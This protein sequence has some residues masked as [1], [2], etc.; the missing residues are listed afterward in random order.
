MTN[1]ADLLHGLDVLFYNARRL[2]VSYSSF[3]PEVVWRHPASLW[4]SVPRDEGHRVALGEEAADGGG[5]G[6]APAGAERG[7]HR[8][9]GPREHRTTGGVTVG[10]QVL[11]LVIIQ[12]LSL[13][14]L[15][16]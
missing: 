7:K 9:R 6:G 14:P 16:I 2:E 3:V 4:P 1:N 15:G 10:R 5:D 8:R 11:D 13:A 12:T